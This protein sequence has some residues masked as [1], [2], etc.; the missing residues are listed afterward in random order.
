MAVVFHGSTNATGATGVLSINKPASTAVGDLLFLH[1]RT[2]QP[3][4]RAGWT[5]A[6]SVGPDATAGYMTMLYRVA[7]GTEPS[8]MTFTIATGGVGQAVMG[9]ISGEDTTTPLDLSPSVGTWTAANQTS[10]T[11]PAITTVSDDCMIISQYVA[12]AAVGGSFSIT[13]PTEQ[14]EANNVMGATQMKAV[15]GLVAA[16]VASYSGSARLVG[17]QVAIRPPPPPVPPSVPRLGMIGI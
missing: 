2:S 12:V 3:I 10:V 11:A 16:Q 7:D 13:G 1:T 9:R 6:Y 4:S 17:A 8:P 5:Q 15:A 14:Y